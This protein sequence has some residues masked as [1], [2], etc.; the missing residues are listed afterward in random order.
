MLTGRQPDGAKRV[1]R[2]PDRLLDAVHPH[3]PTREPRIGQDEVS[4]RL[5]RRR[6]R[7]AIVAVGL[8][9]H[10]RGARRARCGHACTARDEDFATEIHAAAMDER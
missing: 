3:A 6:D 9:L 1:I 5:G 4:R 2:A 7:D 8:D 10:L